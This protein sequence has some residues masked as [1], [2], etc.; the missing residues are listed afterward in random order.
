MCRRSLPLRETNAGRFQV[1]G[2]TLLQS[3][4]PSRQSQISQSGRYSAHVLP[5]IPPDQILC[6]RILGDWMVDR[7]IRYTLQPISVGMLERPPVRNELHL[8]IGID[9]ALFQ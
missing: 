7:N 2:W 8:N 6:L 5:F 4:Y 9:S 1:E 3:R